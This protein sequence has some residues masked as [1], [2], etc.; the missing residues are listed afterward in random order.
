MSIG[1]KAAPW[2]LQTERIHRIIRRGPGPG[3][4]I[5]GINKKAIFFIDNDLAVTALVVA[6]MN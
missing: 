2:R 3:V 6:A 5:F 1:E 4:Y